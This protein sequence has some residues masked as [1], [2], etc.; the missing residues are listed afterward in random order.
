VAIGAAAAGTRTASTGAPPAGFFCGT[1]EPPPR[2]MNVPSESR[3]QGRRDLGVNYKGLQ[4]KNKSWWRRIGAV[5]LGAWLLVGVVILNPFE[6]SD[7][8]PGRRATCVNNIRQLGLALINY[9]GD[10]GTLPPA[11][12]VD[13]D[14]RRLHSWRTLLLPYMDRNRLYDSIRLDE[15]WDSPHNTQVFSQRPLADVGLEIM[16]CPSDELANSIPPMT[17]S[18]VVVVGPDTAFPGSESVSFA[19]IT[20]GPTE[21]LMIVEIADSGICWMEPRDLEVSQMASTINA[22]LGQG[23]CSEH[24]G[25][26]VVTFA[27]GHTTF[28]D[29][30][31]TADTLKALLTIAGGEDIPESAY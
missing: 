10:Q 7:R 13:A 5:V 20:D 29:D 6:L 27:D 26:V 4:V 25:G 8:T 24:P 11:Y 2:M 1:G 17:T 28:L 16:R 19:D 30:T 21:T 22:P 15:P 3:Q 12:T 31:V 14:G 9:E 18:Y 23:M